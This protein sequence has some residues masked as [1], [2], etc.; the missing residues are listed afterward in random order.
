MTRLCGCLPIVRGACEVHD[1]FNDGT[2]CLHTVVTR[3]HH[4]LLARGSC[5]DVT[6]CLH[7]SRVAPTG[8]LHLL[9]VVTG[10]AA[11]IAL[12]GCGHSSATL[13]PYMYM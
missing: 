12:D 8:R 10:S 2:S 11:R 13:D 9:L 7:A 4:V 1:T 6:P 5:R 3:A